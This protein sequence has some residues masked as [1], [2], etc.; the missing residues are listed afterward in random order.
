MP[1]LGG[2][3]YISYDYHQDIWD[4]KILLPCLLSLCQFH[5]HKSAS[6]TLWEMWLLLATEPLSLDIRGWLSLFPWFR[7]R[8]SQG[9]FLVAQH[10]SGARYW[11]DQLWSGCRA[12]SCDTNMAPDSPL[13]YTEA[14]PR[15]KG[16]FWARLP[17]LLTM[18]ASIACPLIA[19]TFVNL[20]LFPA[21]LCRRMSL[22]HRQIVEHLGQNSQRH[23]HLQRKQRL[24][25]FPGK[26]GP[27]IYCEVVEPTWALKNRLA[28]LSASRLAN[29]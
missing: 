21:G 15:G 23:G 13:R 6:C 19:R 25:V 28:R 1:L 5:V 29:L 4:H 16:L 22:R 17:P 7:I 9:R 27:D 8:N 3:R 12:G 20:T 14:S 11:A 18:S 26:P 10:R 2:H 24:R